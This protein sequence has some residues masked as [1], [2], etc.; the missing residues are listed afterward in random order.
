[1][2]V[3]MPKNPLIIIISFICIYA[4]FGFLYALDHRDTGN[5]LFEMF[6]SKSLAAAKSGGP[7]RILL[8]GGSNVIWGYRSQVIEDSIGIPTFNMALLHEANDPKVMRA[9]LLSMLRPGDTVVYASISLW[10]SR[11]LNPEG[12]L[13]LLRVAGLEDAGSLSE[14]A[15]QVFSRYW[16]PVPKRSRLVR[17]LSSLYQRYIELIPGIQARLNE[18]GDIKICE[19][20]TVP[21]AAEYSPTPDFDKYAQELYAFQ[22]RIKTRGARLVI[23]FPPLLIRHEQKEKWLE[24]YRPFWKFIQNRFEVSTKDIADTLLEDQTIFCDTNFHLGDAGAVSR[25][26]V[27]SEYL[28]RNLILAKK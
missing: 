26:L 22:D 21:A 24:S 6:R 18:K 14:R 1:M 9:L 11:P 16:I 15:E 10:N 23:E 7:S 20:N 3:R 19:R 4:C 2:V 17:S 12:A 25:S 27:M 13:E 5:E 8:L 28:R